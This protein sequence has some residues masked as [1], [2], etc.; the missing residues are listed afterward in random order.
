[1][2]KISPDLEYILRITFAFERESAVAN[3]LA[4]TTAIESVLAFSAAA[5]CSAFGPQAIKAMIGK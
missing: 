4:A 3:S 1:V 5:F 2:K